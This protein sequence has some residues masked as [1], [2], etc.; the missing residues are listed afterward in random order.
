VREAAGG[1]EKGREGRREAGLE[2]GRRRPW[3]VVR[4]AVREAVG[5]CEGEA[6]P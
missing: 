1:C 3:E 6:R 4:E 2:G 5:G